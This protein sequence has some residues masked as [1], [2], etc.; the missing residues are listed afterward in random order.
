MAFA[1]LLGGHV[2]GVDPTR[3]V[4]WLVATVASGAGLM[5]LELLSDLAWLGTGKGLTVLVKLARLAL[6][7]IDRRAACGGVGGPTSL[8]LAQIADLLSQGRAFLADP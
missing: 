3:L 4:P 7:P 1:G 8:S 5:A 2:F 6:V